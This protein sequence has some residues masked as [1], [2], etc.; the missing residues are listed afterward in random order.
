MTLNKKIT[1]TLTNGEGSRLD[2]FWT[3]E[4]FRSFYRSFRTGIDLPKTM[5][6]HADNQEHIN[7]KFKLRGF[8]F[9]NWVTV[10]DRYNYLAALYI[11]LYDLNRVLRFKGNNIGLDGRLGISFGSRG[12]S[13]AMAHYEPCTDIINITRYDRPD[14]DEPKPKAHRFI[15]SGGVGAVAH[16]YGHMLDFTFGRMYEPHPE[17]TSLSG[18]DSVARKP[19]QWKTPMR[20]QME[21]ILQMLWWKQTPKGPVKSDYMRRLEGHTKNLY[22]FERC[23]LFARI[24]EQYISY[25]LHQKGIYN[26]FLSHTKYHKGYYLNPREMKAVAPEMAKLIAMMREKF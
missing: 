26:S 15:Y 6:A 2:K 23:E 25:S 8:Q 13:K 7:S 21:T 14:P 11:C 1:D 20:Q 19:T 24:F 9:G 18:D 4:G 12:M 3:N 16:E 22:W 5:A 17:Y 10:E